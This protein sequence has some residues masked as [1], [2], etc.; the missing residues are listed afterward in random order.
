[1]MSRDRR[2]ESVKIAAGLLRR[3]G[4]EERIPS[5]KE[6]LDYAKAIDGYLYEGEVPDENVQVDLRRSG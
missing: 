1:M 3:M 5:V 4:K 6:V 2:A